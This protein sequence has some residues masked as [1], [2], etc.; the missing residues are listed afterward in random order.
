MHSHR[1]RERDSALTLVQGKKG[2]MQGQNAK[3]LVKTKALHVEEHFL[4]RLC[5]SRRTS[6]THSLSPNPNPN[7][8]SFGAEQCIP[9]CGI[10]EGI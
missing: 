5:S 9:A 6:T 4:A 3:M 7:P 10:V 2:E 8:N 1:V